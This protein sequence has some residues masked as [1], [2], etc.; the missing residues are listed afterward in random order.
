MTSRHAMPPPPTRLPSRKPSGRQRIGKMALPASLRVPVTTERSPTDRFAST[1][2]ATPTSAGASAKV[3]LTLTDSPEGAAADA[4][5]LAP[6]PITAG[7]SATVKPT[8]RLSGSGIERAACREDASF[9][10]E[11]HHPQSGERID[12]NGEP[13]AVQV[14][15]VQKTRCKLVRNADGTITAI[16][17]PSQSGKYE[18]VVSHRGKQIA[19]SPWMVKTFTPEPHAPLCSI[20]GHG[21]F[22]AV[23][24]E[25]ASFEVSFRDQM[26]AVSAAQF[27]D[28]FVEEAWTNRAAASRLPSD[29]KPTDDL[30]AY[31]DRHHPHVS[32]CRRL[33]GDVRGVVVGPKPLAVRATKDVDCKATVG[34]LPAGTVVLV[35]QLDEAHLPDRLEGL[36]VA[37]ASP[38]ADLSASTNLIEGWATLKRGGQQGIET[39]SRLDT[40]LKAEHVKHWE[41]QM[42]T[43]K[44]EQAGKAGVS[45]EQQG[46]EKDAAERSAA[47][48]VAAPSGTPSGKSEPAAAGGHPVSSTARREGA[49]AEETP[50]GGSVFIEELKLTLDPSGFSYGGAYPGVLH[51]KGVIHEWH[52][53]SYTVSIAGTYL[54]HVR[55]R[56][57]KEAL[58]LPGSPFLLTVS[59]GLP[60]GPSTLFGTPGTGETGQRRKIL[61][62]GLDKVGN[63]V[64]VSGAALGGC[65]L[66]HLVRGVH[67]GV[68]ADDLETEIVDHQDGTYSFFA[69]STRPGT[70]EVHMSFAPDGLPLLGS[71]AKLL[72]RST[73]PDMSRCEIN[74]PGISSF[75]TNE[76]ATIRVTLNDAYGNRC[77]PS[78][79]FTDSCKFGMS[80]M[81]VTAQMLAANKGKR[82]PISDQP[83]FPDFGGTW[84]VHDTKDGGGTYFELKYT[85]SEGGAG[86]SLQ[87]WYTKG[88]EGMQ[89]ASVS[90]CM[91][92]PLRWERVWKRRQ[93]KRPQS[94]PFRPHRRSR[95]RRSR[96]SQ[97]IMPS[98]SACLMKCRR[99][100]ASVRSTSLRARR[101]RSVDASTF[102]ATL[103]IRTQTWEAPRARMPSK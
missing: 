19:G 90:A 57:A 42:R 15:G 58:P 50:T 23:A 47:A 33:L 55:L 72:F 78:A 24:R 97:E 29:S 79:T 11:A 9:V 37:A 66:K 36:V 51:A 74:G 44:L 14:R 89:K 91:R 41:R 31:F 59:P 99:G 68:S 71:P 26:G 80:M 63:A 101:P 60:Y 3:F 54:L 5:E 27:L 34:S 76:A 103:R 21:I 39:R 25:P 28:V 2:Q 8:F 30:S 17:K 4:H 82:M 102:P 35:L 20:R 94:R 77:H 85:R 83:L 53:V 65:S 40:G 22:T 6:A 13:V 61:I 49:G 45:T 64:T 98:Q 73:I 43:D 96:P 69:T 1:P 16:W 86:I 32:A 7:Q 48:P 81:V 84:K 46:A 18:I 38:L 10:I 56:G 12:L 100:G 95:C 62:R 92:G 93:A 52:K 75:K 67:G 70:Y 87:L 88:A